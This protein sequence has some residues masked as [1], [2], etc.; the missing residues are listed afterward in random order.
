MIDTIAVTAGPTGPTDFFTGFIQARS[1]LN[2]QRLDLMKQNLPEEIAMIS[3]NQEFLA[4]SFHKR[5]LAE[6]EKVNAA[7]HNLRDM[8]QADHNA[9]PDKSF[10]KAKIEGDPNDA[11]D[12]KGPC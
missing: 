6:A 12:S 3:G 2:Q 4:K 11:E 9:G 1:G 5:V 7:I 8:I 10:L